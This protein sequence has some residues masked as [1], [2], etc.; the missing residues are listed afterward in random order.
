MKTPSLAADALILFGEGIV[1]IRRENPPYRGSYALPGGFVEVGETVEEAVRR[2]AKEE[3]G[4][5]ITL[6]KLVGVYSK[7]DRDPRGHVVSVCY[8]AWGWGEISAGSD[9]SAAEVFGPEVLPPLAFD[10]A[11][12]VRDGLEKL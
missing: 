3:T 5:D 8:L 9:A 1:L 2:E 4:L 10:H 12:M 11:S 7:P 6:L